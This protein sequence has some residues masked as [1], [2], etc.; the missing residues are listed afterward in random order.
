MLTDLDMAVLAHV[1]EQYDESQQ[2]V[3]TADLAG[4]L[5]AD[6]SEIRDCLGQLVANDLLAVVGDGYRPTI[7]ARELLALDI[8]FEDSLV[9]L[10]F[11]APEAGPS[12]DTREERENG[13][14]SEGNKHG[15][16]FGDNS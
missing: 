3:M 7:T 15:H 14:E 2:R 13:H 6:E 10:D 16:E 9:V 8:D 5:D 1:V 4:A 12:V 11:D